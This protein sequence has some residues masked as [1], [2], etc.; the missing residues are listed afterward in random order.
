MLCAEAHTPARLPL[1]WLN[2]YRSAIAVEFSVRP[3][4]ELWNGNL[5]DG[6]TVQMALRDQGLRCGPS[7][8][9]VAGEL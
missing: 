6:L 5:A 7:T 3:Q 1:T 4:G 2:S 9:T 8:A